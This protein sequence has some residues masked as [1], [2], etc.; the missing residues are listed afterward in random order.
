M[1][2][3]KKTGKS[4]AVMRGGNSFCGGKVFKKPPN[5]CNN[6]KNWEATKQ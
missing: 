3:N 5:L 4:Q 1:Y 6:C 2:L